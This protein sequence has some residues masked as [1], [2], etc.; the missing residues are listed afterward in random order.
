[1]DCLAASPLGS[2][3]ASL[4]FYHEDELAPSR[5]IFYNRPFVDFF[6]LAMKQHLFMYSYIREIYPVKSAH[7]TGDQMVLRGVLNK[8]DPI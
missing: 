3:P 1:M 5:N 2:I 4:V 7:K 6:L 8:S